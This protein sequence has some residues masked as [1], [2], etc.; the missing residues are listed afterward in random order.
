MLVFWLFTG[1]LEDISSEGGL[2]ELLK[3]GLVVVLGSP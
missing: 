1:K 3:H 2:Q